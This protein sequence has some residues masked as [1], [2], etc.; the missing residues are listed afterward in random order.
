MLTGPCSWVVERPWL[1]TSR[2][3][4]GNRK[5]SVSLG[6]AEKSDVNPSTSSFSGTEVGSIRLAMLQ[7]TDSA[8]PNS[9]T[10]SPR[11]GVPSSVVKTKSESLRVLATNEST[12]ER[13]Q[14]KD[15]AIGIRSVHY[16]ILR[17]SYMSLCALACRTQLNLLLHY[18]DNH[19][20]Y[21]AL[22]VSVILSIYRESKD[23][24]A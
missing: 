13:G 7:L 4:R 14:C 8:P 15:S 1:R 6:S 9:F 3:W 11:Q 24:C 10:P 19:F 17:S 5:L 20:V 12:R 21:V 16:V 18:L 2:R 22:L 23:S